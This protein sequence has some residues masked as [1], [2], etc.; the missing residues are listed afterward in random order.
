[1]AREVEDQFTQLVPRAAGRAAQFLGVLKQ[2]ND[3][4]GLGIPLA[5]T[6]RSFRDKSVV[7]RGKVPAGKGNAVELEVFADPQGSALHVGW[8]V[9]R[10]VVGG[11]LSGIGMMQEFN[12]QNI[13]NSGKASN[14]RQLTGAMTAFQDLVFLP[15]LQQLVEAVE[16]ENAGPRPNGFLG[17]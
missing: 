16:A 4:E 1:M 12:F 17:A 10:N 14:V 15:V 5:A 6:N 11:A 2:A 13:K 9:Q 3:T 7:L 8:Q